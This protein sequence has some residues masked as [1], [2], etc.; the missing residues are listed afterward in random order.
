[1]RKSSIT[2][3]REK[4]QSFT[5]LLGQGREWIAEVAAATVLVALAATMGAKEKNIVGGGN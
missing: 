1:M 3:S 4:C 2:L 5:E